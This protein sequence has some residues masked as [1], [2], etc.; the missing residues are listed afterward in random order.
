M[1]RTGRPRTYHPESPATAAE[2]QAR[3]RAKL[4]P[5]LPTPVIVGD[6][7]LY[8]GDARLV[9]PTLKDIG[10]ILTD[11]PY[12][13]ITH[14]GARGGGMKQAHLIDFAAMTDADAVRLAQQCCALAQRWVVMTM[15]WRH[16]SVVE[17]HCP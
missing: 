17:K 4:H 12:S 8:G 2:R 14:A 1:P 13:A 5:T 11:P 15:D 3:W 6:C 10:A 16:A 9:W 7:T